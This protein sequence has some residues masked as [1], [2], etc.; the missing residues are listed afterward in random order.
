MIRELARMPLKNFVLR[1][2]ASYKETALLISLSELESLLTQCKES[3]A[4]ERSDIGQKLEAAKRAAAERAAAEAAKKNK[5][6][7]K[8]IG[9]AVGGVLGGP[10][11]AMAGYQIGSAIDDEL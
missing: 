2:V 10:V 9:A 4:E 5:G 3:K 1:R 8:F 6:F 11:G 7:T